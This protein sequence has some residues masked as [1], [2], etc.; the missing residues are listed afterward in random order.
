ML[1]KQAQTEPVLRFHFVQL[2][3]GRDRDL[4]VNVTYPVVIIVDANITGI[5][6]HRKQVSLKVFD[7]EILVAANSKQ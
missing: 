5:A 6:V 1:R 2:P 7:R 3:G 4:R